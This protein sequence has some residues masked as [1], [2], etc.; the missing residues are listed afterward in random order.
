MNN[1]AIIPARGGSKRIPGKNIKDFLGKP[2]IAY[3]IEMAIESKLFSEVMVS[4]DDD[5]IAKIALSYGA[6]IPFMRSK[7]T[8]NDKS[9]IAE[10]LLEVIQNYNREFKYICCILPTAPFVTPELLEKGF[11]LITRNNLDS[12]FPIVKFDYPI[13]RALKIENNNL[14]LIWPENYHKRSQDLIP[15]YHDCGQFY[16]INKDSF[17][18]Q[19][20]VMMNNSQGIE[21]SALQAQDIDDETDWGIAQIKYN[22]AFGRKK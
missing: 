16:W 2:I 17:F 18:K 11:N 10:V 22:L 13:Q 7:K 20:I 4:T 3:S 21:V 5:E 6:T 15:T 8:S 14:S 9:G 1:L 19:K 12:V